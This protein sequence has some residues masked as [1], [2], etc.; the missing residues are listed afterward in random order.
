MASHPVTLR[1]LSLNLWNTDGPWP[2]RARRIGEWIDRLDPD[3]LAFQEVVRVAGCD[4]LDELLAGRGYHTDYVAASPFWKPDREDVK[5]EVGN[6]VAS[7]WPIRAREE[8]QL[9]GTGDFETRTA[10]SVEVTAPFGPVS[11]TVTHLNWRLDHGWVREQQAQA[12]CELALRHA[13]KRGFPP[14]LVGDFNA[15]PDATEIRY[16]TGLHALEGRSV[17]LLDA[18]ARAGDGTPGFTWSNTNA[19]ARL[20]REPD[21]RIDYV[22]AGLPRRDGLGELLGCRVVCNDEVDGVWPS[23]HFGVYA[24]LRSE[25]LPG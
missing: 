24:E 14:L 5:G 18:W 3:L 12:V 8:L 6:A 15:E 9:P 13:P 23:D 22:F 19:W 2:A 1:V 11:F 20:E 4:Q 7:R 16:V 17:C 21:R 10:L 25:A